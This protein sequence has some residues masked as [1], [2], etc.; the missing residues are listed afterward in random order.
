M[1]RI[2]NNGI[3]GSGEGKYN[4]EQNLWNSVKKSWKIEQGE[5]SLISF[6]A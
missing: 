1:L 6:F 2:Q 5:K 3:W 4:R